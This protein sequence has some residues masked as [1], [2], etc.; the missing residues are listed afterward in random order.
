[1]DMNQTVSFFK[2]LTEPDIKEIKSLAN[3]IFYAKDD[4]IFSQGDEANSFYIIDKG[5]LSVYYNKNGTDKELCT[6]TDNDYFGEMAIY[7][8]DKRSASVK[9]IEDSN[10]F[11]ID[12]NVF[13]NFVDKHPLLAEKIH[14]NLA[15]RNEE[16]ALREN[17][18]DMTGLSGKRLHISIKGD[19]SLRESAF[20]RERYESV[21]DKLMDKLEPNLEELLLNRCVYRLFLN[22]NSGEIRTASIFD[23]F[24]EEIHTPDKLIDKAYLDRHFPI[25]SFDEKARMIK[26]IYQFI[27]SDSHFNQLPVHCRNIIDKSHDIWQPVARE[28]ISRVMNKLGKLRSIQSFYLRNFSISM[29]VDA[30]RMQFNCDG[31]HIVSSE[32][33]QHFLNDNLE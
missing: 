28:E 17:L 20:M 4:L 19:P 32:D 9:A 10:L 16:L 29:I 12:K 24:I 11:E 8:Q 26:S 15:L 25:I 14:G 31:T 22:F 13:F 18:V 3:N 23:P 6:L 21:V 5:R 27:S 33:Y 30:I 2:E 7:N 1:M